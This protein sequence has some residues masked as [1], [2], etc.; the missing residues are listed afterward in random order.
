MIYLDWVDPISMSVVTNEC[1]I[2]YLDKPRYRRRCQSMPLGCENC[3]TR[4]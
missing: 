1:R 3:R 4:T 2:R